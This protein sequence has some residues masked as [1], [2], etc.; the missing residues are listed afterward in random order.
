LAAVLAKSD[1]VHRVQVH[2]PAG[3]GSAERV[4][5]ES[6]TVPVQLAC[7]T[8]TRRAGG[9]CALRFD[10]GSERTEAAILTPATNGKARSRSSF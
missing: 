4:A 10:A 2:V 6:E 5:P 8:D 3:R 7:E 1:W 9:W